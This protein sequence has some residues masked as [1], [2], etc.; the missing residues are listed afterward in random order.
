MSESLIHC[1]IEAKE[2]KPTK[3]HYA[4]LVA[5]TGEEHPDDFYRTWAEVVR[6]VC[7]L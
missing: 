7:A 1:L 5:F 2:C 4:E 6:R 3:E